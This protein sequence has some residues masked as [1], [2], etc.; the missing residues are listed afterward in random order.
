MSANNNKLKDKLL[1]LCLNVTNEQLENKELNSQITSISNF[2][3]NLEG[4]ILSFSRKKVTEVPENYSQ[5]QYNADLKS[6]YF[7]YYNW[8]NQKSQTKT[9]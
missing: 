1:I 4:S 8:E 3:Q 2:L 5:L 9:E 7:D 6:Q